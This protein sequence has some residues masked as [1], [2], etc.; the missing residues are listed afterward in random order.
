[1]DLVGRRLPVLEGRRGSAIPVPVSIPISIP[2]P[3]AVSIPISIPISVPVPVSVPVS[4]PIS[5]ITAPVITVT[6]AGT[7]CG[8]QNENGHEADDSTHRGASSHARRS[9]RQTTMTYRP[10][11]SPPRRICGHDRASFIEDVQLASVSIQ[12]RH[13]PG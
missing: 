12:N 5:L 3:I 8:E 9:H 4:N 11:V 2:V 13:R 6:L 7:D 10:A 1:M